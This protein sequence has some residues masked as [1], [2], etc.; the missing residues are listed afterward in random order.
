MWIFHVQQVLLFGI[1]DH[2]DVLVARHPQTGDLHKVVFA[3]GRSMGGGVAQSMTKDPKSTLVYRMCAYKYYSVSIRITGLAQP[4]DIDWWCWLAFFLSLY[5]PIFGLHLQLMGTNV[6][7]GRNLSPPYVNGS[8]RTKKPGSVT[9]VSSTELPFYQAVLAESMN[10]LQVVEAAIT[11]LRLGG[12]VDSAAMTAEKT[13]LTNVDLAAVQSVKVFAHQAMRWARASTHSEL[14]ESVPA[15]EPPKLDLTPEQVQAIH[16][17][18]PTL[19]TVD[20]KADGGEQAFE[21]DAESI[22][23]YDDDV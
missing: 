5:G 21:V 10:A 9:F 22:S 2:P 16:P 14:A 7:M 23:D 6:C 18:F 20:S 4:D 12:F 17:L 13:R 11:A 19:W 3:S 1:A 15:S 8:K